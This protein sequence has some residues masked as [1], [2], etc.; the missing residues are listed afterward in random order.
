MSDKPVLI[1]IVPCYNEEAVLPRAAE[2]LAEKIRQL[3]SL[4]LISRQSALLFVD[5]C[6]SDNT[7]TLIEKYHGDSPLLF[8]GIRLPANRGQQAALFC[9]LLSVKDYADAAVSIDADLQDDIEA[10]DKMLELFLS[11]YEIVMGVRS[12][13]ESDSFFKR[14]GA[15]FFYRFM[16]LL[17][18]NLADNHADFR[19]MG[20]EAIKALA[21][22]NGTTLFLR[23]IVPA[24]GYKTGTVYYKRKRRLTGKTKYT[25]RKMCGLAID[26]IF[27]V[28]I[29]GKY[30]GRLYAKVKRPP[31]YCVEKK[32]L[33]WESANGT[34]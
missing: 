8:N 10:I 3:V 29:V 31:E 33:A 13:R 12:G 11:G 7:W 28:G 2:C 9:G 26:G 27:S 6:S 4:Q 17:G 20:R 32:L 34:R 21:K 30:L 16:R 24:L 25:V 22:Y 18:A 5:D 14:T 19:L 1:I 15:L 23:G